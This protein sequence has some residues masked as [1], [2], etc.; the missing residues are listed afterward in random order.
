MAMVPGSVS[1]DAGGVASG[2]GYAK[3]VYDVLEAG[4]DFGT[5]T[6]PGLVTA[7]QQ[8][9]DIANACAALITHVQSNA[10]V[11]TTGSG[12]SPPFTSTGTGTI[13]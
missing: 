11:S 1:I 12:T 5:L 8:L 10:V 13:A 7:K 9:A 3:E 4:T 2:T 6:P